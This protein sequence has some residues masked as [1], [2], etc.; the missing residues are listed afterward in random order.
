MTYV[1]LTVSLIYRHPLIDKDSVSLVIFFMQVW[2][3]NEIGHSLNSWQAYQTFSVKFNQSE[4][5]C[6][7]PFS[8]SRITFV[9]NLRVNAAPNCDH[10]ESYTEITEVQQPEA[11]NKVIYLLIRN[12]F[13]WYSQVNCKV[14]L[15][16][17][18]AILEVSPPSKAI[19]FTISL[20][21]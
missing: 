9:S 16:F 20:C 6:C 14:E 12:R 5:L 7:N 18:L 21:A 13:W 3:I 8:T 11:D 2:K 10:F 19:L 17:W 15:A 1:L 4:P